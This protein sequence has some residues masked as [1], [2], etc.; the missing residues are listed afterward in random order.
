M[1]N[2]SLIEVYYLLKFNLRLPIT[3]LYS[4]SGT[5]PIIW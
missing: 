3:I 4:V 2:F 1:K 5:H